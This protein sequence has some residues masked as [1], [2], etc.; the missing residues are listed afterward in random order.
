MTDWRSIIVNAQAAYV[1]KPRGKSPLSVITRSGRKAAPNPGFQVNE[2]GARV[3]TGAPDGSL[4]G[5]RSATRWT[6]PNTRTHST[7]AAKSAHR[8]KFAR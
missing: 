2:L 8:S 6:T 3:R 5:D 7:R 4:H 1:A